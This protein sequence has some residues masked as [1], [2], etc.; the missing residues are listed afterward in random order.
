MQS[1]ACKRHN[2]HGMCQVNLQQVGRGIELYATAPTSTPAGP[3][4]SAK[5]YQSMQNAARLTLT[6]AQTSLMMILS[7]IRL[8]AH[9][10][11][12]SGDQKSS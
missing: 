11:A 3:I 1:S 7:C 4:G 5:L 2:Q 6:A 10:A 12:D 9:W 8:S